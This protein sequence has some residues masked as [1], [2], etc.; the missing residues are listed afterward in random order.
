MLL[1]LGELGEAFDV[2]ELHGDLAPHAAQ[3]ERL[4]QIEKAADEF[5]MPTEGEAGSNG[6]QKRPLWQT[7]SGRAF[8]YTGRPAVRVR[9][10]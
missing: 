10:M 5:V 7:W 2:G 6:G 8:R 9:A 4:T 1:G 3:L